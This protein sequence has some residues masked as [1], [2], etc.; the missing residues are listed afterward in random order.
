MEHADAEPLGVGVE[1]GLNKEVEKGGVGVNGMA[2]AGAAGDPAEE[3]HGRVD[4]DG[5]R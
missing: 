2:E 1:L 4:A 5:E 3:G